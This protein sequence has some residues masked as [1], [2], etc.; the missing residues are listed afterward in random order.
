[1]SPL[2]T[3]NCVEVVGSWVTNRRGC[4]KWVGCVCGLLQVLCFKNVSDTQ[5]LGSSRDELGTS[6][7]NSR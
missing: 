7:V 1:M 5:I 6:C 3:K 4:V 2:N